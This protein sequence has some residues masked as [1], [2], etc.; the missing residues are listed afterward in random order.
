MFAL[1]RARKLLLSWQEKYSHRNAF[2]II[3]VSN[4]RADYLS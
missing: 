2:S 4:L 3:F 1:E